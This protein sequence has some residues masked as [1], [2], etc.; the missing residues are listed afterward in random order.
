MGR[1]Y[2]ATA[3]G[4]A[5]ERLETLA[6]ILACRIDECDDFKD[7]SNLARQYRETVKA[8]NE[9]DG[10]EDDGEDA[11]LDSLIGNSAPTRKPKAD[12]AG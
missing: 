9:L 12:K 11:E 4:G 3:D 1:L 6:R 5:I 2:D 8:I 7:M 10:G